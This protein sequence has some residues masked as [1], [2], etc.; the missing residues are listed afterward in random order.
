MYKYFSV[1]YYI[2]L[3]HNFAQP[4]LFNDYIIYMDILQLSSE[5]EKAVDNISRA[6]LMAKFLV[7]NKN[8]Y[9]GD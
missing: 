6:N 8:A 7:K 9:W 2:K 5:C 1:S 4:F 3:L